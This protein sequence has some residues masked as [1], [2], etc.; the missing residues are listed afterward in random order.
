[1]QFTCLSRPL[2]NLIGC[3]YGFKSVPSLKDQIRSPTYTDL[4]QD[5]GES[6]LK[7][8]VDIYLLGGRELAYH[9]MYVAV[10]GQHSRYHS[11]L[12][13]R[14]FWDPAQVIIYIDNGI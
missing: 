8:L 7:R 4:F 10:K 2:M 3:P 5:K 1:M 13:P 12:P 14:V 6:Y 11:L 9:D